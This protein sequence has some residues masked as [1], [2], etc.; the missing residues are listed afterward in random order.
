MDRTIDSIPLVRNYTV[1]FDPV[2]K[3]ILAVGDVSDFC[4]HPRLRVV[5]ELL[6]GGENFIEPVTVKQF[7][8]VAAPLH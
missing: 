1:I 6:P 2:I 4:P 7:V 3:L 5:H 8:G